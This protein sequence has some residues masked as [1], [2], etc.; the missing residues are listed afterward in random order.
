MD[1]I[2]RKIMLVDDNLTNLSV[3]KNVLKDHYQVFVLPSA[4]KLFEVLP[5]VTPDLILLD[6]EMPEMNGYEAVQKLKA[7]AKTA[8]IPV[9]FLSSS[10]DEASEAEG[11]ALGAVDFVRKP[12]S[13]PDLIGRIEKHLSAF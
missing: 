10:D 12:F 6:I 7:D 4:A 5:N 1:G 9:I 3:G 11:R 2:R 13:A 8:G